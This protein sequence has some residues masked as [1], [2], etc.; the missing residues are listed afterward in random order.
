[1]NFAVFYFNR[2]LPNPSLVPLVNSSCLCVLSSAVQ[3]ILQ[4]RCCESRDRQ[5]FSWWAVKWYVLLLHTGSLIL[6][7]HRGW[8]YNCCPLHRRSMY[9]FEIL[10]PLAAHVNWALKVNT[11]ISI[12]VC[13]DRNTQVEM[14]VCSW[15]F[16]FPHIDSPYCGNSRR[17]RHIRSNKL[18][19]SCRRLSHT[20]I[21]ET[22]PGEPLIHSLPQS[23]ISF[24]ISPLILS[25]YLCLYHCFN[26]KLKVH[27]WCWVKISSLPLNCSQKALKGPLGSAA[28]SGPDL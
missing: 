8:N 11:S 24:F 27:L 26:S 23:S 25:L 10:P 9:P 12:R 4:P 13:W 20:L 18:F 21:T 16:N 22:S 14:W 17:E 15:C 2:L 1:M 6:Q 3:Y 28:A 5:A 7:L 19:P